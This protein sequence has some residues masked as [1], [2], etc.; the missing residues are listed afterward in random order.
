VSADDG[1]WMETEQTGQSANW[2]W[3]FIIGPVVMS[4]LAVTLSLVLT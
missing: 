2:M 3:L 4:A 1:I